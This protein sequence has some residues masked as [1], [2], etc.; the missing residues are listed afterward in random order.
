MRS[1]VKWT[2]AVAAT[3]G[4]VTGAAHA[5]TIVYVS[6]ADSRTISVMKLDE[7]TGKL[8]S[9]E[10]V[11]VTGTVM[12]LTVSP[13]RKYLF[14]SL[15]SKPYSVASFRIEGDG[16]LTPVATSPLPESMANLST[17]QTGHF[18][19]AASYGGNLISESRIA[20]D[21]VVAP[22]NLVIPT[23]PKAHAIKTDP[24]NRWLF[25]T[26]LGGDI[27]MQ[28]RFD[29]KT[30]AITPNDPPTLDFPSKAG[31]RHFVF[32]PNGRVV[33]VVDELD[34]KLEMA[35]FDPERGTLAIRQTVSVV[36]AGFSGTPWAA[37]IHTT[38]DGRFLYAS[39]RTSSTL[40]AYR[41]DGPDGRLSTLGEYATEKQPR[42]FAIDSPG[43]YLLS[44]G[45]LS[46]AVSVHRIDPQ[47][48]QLTRLGSTLVGKNPSWVEIV[49]VK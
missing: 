39:E 1:L 10:D 43:R 20:P 47:T 37:D 11:P 46:N 19:F 14:A 4:F 24:S 5:A 31:P 45:Q 44:A 49:D 12:P 8:S 2:S 13:D 34:G 42:A 26:N 23:K 38:P 7:D 36:P 28:C 3:L 22:A 48:G 35:A 32:H 41:I 18:L 6:N 33:Y 25:A 9:I 17:D 27:V 21:G 15:R 16:R 40:L 30:G 29:A